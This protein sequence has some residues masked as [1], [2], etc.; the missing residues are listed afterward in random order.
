MQAWPFQFLG[1]GNMFDY[2][3]VKREREK[4]NKTKHTSMQ[5]DMVAPRIWPRIRRKPF[6]TVPS[7]SRWQVTRYPTT[8]QVPNCNVFKP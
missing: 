6:F 2:W 5:N 3:C 7:Y 1:E 8:L 4:N